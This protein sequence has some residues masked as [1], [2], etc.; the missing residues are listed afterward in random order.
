[1]YNLLIKYNKIR[2]QIMT[3]KKT[4]TYIPGEKVKKRVRIAFKD[5]GVV[6]L[7]ILMILSLLI[8][9]IVAFTGTH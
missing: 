4:T 5:I 2:L 1:M 8:P 7:V 3:K 9:S 6:I